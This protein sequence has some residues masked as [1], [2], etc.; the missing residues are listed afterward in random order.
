AAGAG[1]PPAPAAAGAARPAPAAPA[2]VLPAGLTVMRRE[3]GRWEIGWHSAEPR[4]LVV[5]ESWAPGWRALVDGQPRPV[6]AAAGALL[7][8]RLG[9]GSGRAEL[10]YRPPG[11]LAGAGISAAALLVLTA[12]AAARVR[13]AA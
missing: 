4:L 2:A 11:L 12:L 10:R 6:E 5:A 9:P 1:S 13:G 3:P 7:G 8:V